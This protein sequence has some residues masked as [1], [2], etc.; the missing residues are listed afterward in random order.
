[1][2][3]RAQMEENIATMADFRPLDEE[4]LALLDRVRTVYQGMHKV[5]CTACRYC[6]DGC[7]AGIDIPELFTRLND[8]RQNVEGA[9]ARYAAQM[10]KADSCVG[11]GQCETACPQRLHIRE[12]L[13]DVT[14]AF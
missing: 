6:V 12:L 5:P 3:D 4:E 11:C 14:A 1:M 13:K 7:P 10:V 8:K 2:S 9:D